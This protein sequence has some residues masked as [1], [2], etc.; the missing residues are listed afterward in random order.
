VQSWFGLGLMEESERRVLRYFAP[1]AIFFPG[2]LGSDNVMS[3]NVAYLL[4]GATLFTFARALRSGRWSWFYA[5]VLAASCFKAPMLTL[6]AIPVLCA[7]RQWLPACGAGAAGLAL[8]AV[9]PMLW[10]QLFQNYLKAVGLQFSF[11][12]D[13]GDAPPGLFSGWR[14]DH[15][16]SY[17][18][19]G[20]IFYAVFAIAVFGSLLYLSSRYYLSGEWSTER[21]V[22]VMLI[23]VILLNPR[24]ME[25]DVAPLALPMA[26]VC[27]RLFSGSRGTRTTL[28]CAGAVFVGLNMV[29]THTW[30]LWKT[31]EGT[32]LVALFVGGAL[33]L[34]RSPAVSGEPVGIPGMLTEA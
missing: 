1:I 22:P 18:P 6:L 29:A 9:Q 5:A 30:T 34:L 4:Y 20:E 31:T 32:L 2:L 27:W 13:F 16:L 3:G 28:A 11:N 33:T 7:R 8:F 15:H 12:R 21:W 23:G 25:Y 19:A 14:F 17:S 26:I 10:P 24:P